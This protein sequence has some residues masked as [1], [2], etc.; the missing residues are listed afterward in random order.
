M[1]LL[2]ELDDTIFKE[3]SFQFVKVNFNDLAWHDANLL[4]I[5]IDRNLPGE[6]DKV[7]LLIKWPNDSISIIEFY[8]CYAFK[9]SVNFGIVANEYI[10]NSKCFTNSEELMSIWNE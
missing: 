1:T 6:Q 4:S 2:V 3:Q 8:E 7:R 5:Y 9:A 10:L